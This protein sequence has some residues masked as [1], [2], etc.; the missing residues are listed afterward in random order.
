MGIMDLNN[1]L[2]EIH[3]LDHLK[4][5]YEFCMIEPK[6]KKEEKDSVDRTDCHEG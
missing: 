1:T 4:K 3:G 5:D 6:F 2:C